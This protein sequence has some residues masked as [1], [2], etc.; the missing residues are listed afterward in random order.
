M[1][2]PVGNQ[3]ISLSY[4]GVFDFEGLYKIMV[5]WFKARRFWFH[6]STYKFKPGQGWGKEVEIRWVAEKK[7]DEFTKYFVYINMHLW[8]WN[9]VEVMRNGVK[10]KMVNARMEIVFRT[11]CLYDWQNM[12]TK[13]EFT[14]SLF[15][16]MVNYLMRYKVIEAHPDLI[17]YRVYKLHNIIKEF[18]EMEARGNEFH[19]YLGDV[20]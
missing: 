7:T 9:E 13:S 2:W 18:L 20:S 10:K 14:Q 3:T 19:G 4:K 5:Q 12:F 16:F 17:Y 8:H 15:K 6:E 1:S 11:I